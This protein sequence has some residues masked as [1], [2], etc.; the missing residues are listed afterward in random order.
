[1]KAI[2]VHEY[3]SLDE[4]RLE[5]V[6]DPLAGEGEVLIEV[7]SAAVNPID[8]KILSGAMKAFIPLPLPYTPGTE[9][10]GTIGAIGKGV[11]GFAVGDKVFGFI[12]IAGG[13]ATKVA[14]PAERVALRPRSLSAQQASGVA[15]AALTAWQALH[16]QAGI[17]AGQRVLI[18]GAA[19]GV[20]SMAVQIARQAGAT[21]IAT[22]SSG[23]H[24]Y[25][26]KI[27]A[28]QVIDYRSQAFEEV[29]ADVDIVLDLIGGE[30]QLRSWTVLKRG[31]VLV[32]P[33]SAPNAELAKAHGASAKNFATR[34]DG[35]QLTAIAELFDAGQLS[36]EVAVFPLSQVKQAV[37]K[38]RA[39]HTRGKI[40]LNLGQ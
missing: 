29:V 39:G 15:T 8:W 4:L 9:V 38:S 22:A 14:V 30:T 7:E 17:K 5:D 3:G 20:G 37:E 40:V 26:E 6:V 36:V 18:H 16:E 10:A 2:R 35:R 11:S 21:V 34:P 24:G 19:G 32:S 23:N 28:N 13:Y 25:L 27:G 1:M 33:V 31:G 12:G